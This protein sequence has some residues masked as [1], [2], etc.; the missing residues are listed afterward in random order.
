MNFWHQLL[1][2]HINH[3]STLI[4]TAASPNT[5]AACSGVPLHFS[6]PNSLLMSNPE[7]IQS[8]GWSSRDLIHSPIFASS[9]SVACP[10][11]PASD[12]APHVTVQVHYIETCGAERVL[13]WPIISAHHQEGCCACCRGCAKQTS[14]NLPRHSHSMTGV[15]LSFSSLTITHL[16]H[17]HK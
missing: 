9:V 17:V 8:C 11:N 13:V 6:V 12:R 2:P 16:R 5:T 1:L 14:W 10:T 3:N 4:T 15:G 7:L